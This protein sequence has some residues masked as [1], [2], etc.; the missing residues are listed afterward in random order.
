MLTQQPNTQAMTLFATLE[1]DWRLPMSF[2][3]ISAPS[4]GLGTMMAA[5]AVLRTRSDA[6]AISEESD[7]SA[8]A[9]GVIATSRVCS[10]IPTSPAFPASDFA[11]AGEPG[12]GDAGPPETLGD[13]QGEDLGASPHADPEEVAA[14]AALE[15][16]LAAAGLALAGLGPR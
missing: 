3:A 1:N 12:L 4:A 8:H 7:I 11:A 9:R 16:R 5:A 10:G 13:P 6:S 2:E 14:L 15:A